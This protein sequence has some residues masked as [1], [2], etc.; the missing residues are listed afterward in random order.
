MRFN[1]S[2][3][4]RSESL[5]SGADCWL[6]TLHVTATGILLGPYEIQKKSSLMHKT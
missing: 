1:R 5:V 3:D 2:Q 6:E 4:N